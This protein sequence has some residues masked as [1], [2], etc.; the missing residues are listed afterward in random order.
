[1]F[2]EMNNYQ[3]RVF[4]LA[5]C[6]LL[7]AGCLLLVACYWLLVAGCDPAKREGA[8]ATSRRFGR[9][10]RFASIFG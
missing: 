8:F 3:Q 6:L 10:L 2:I 4:I 7:V 5:C 9:D 1:M